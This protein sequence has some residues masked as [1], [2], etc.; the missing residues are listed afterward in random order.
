MKI[1]IEVKSLI[2]L[3]FLNL[4]V[5]VFPVWAQNNI[6]ILEA[7]LNEKLSDE[8]RIDTQNEL[9][10]HF[11][12]SN[13][14]RALKLSNQTLVNS[15]KLHYL[16]GIGGALKVQGALQ[17]LAGNIDTALIFYKSSIEAFEE[18]Q[19]FK[20]QAEVYLLWGNLL[21]SQDDIDAAVE[22]YYRGLKIAG[23]NETLLT[24]ASLLMSIGAI[25]V[26]QQN[27]SEAESLYKSAIEIQEQ[28]GLPSKYAISYYHLAT[29]YSKTG[30][31][32]SA[33]V[34][35]NKA[36]SIF[37][38]PIAKN[39]LASIY[40]SK[41]NV[42]FQMKDYSKA[43]YFYEKGFRLKKELGNEKGLANSYHQVG[44]L[45]LENGLLD[46]AEEYLNQSLELAKELSMIDLQAKTCK[47]MSELF[48]QLDKPEDAL[49]YYQQHIILRDSIRNQET[50]R[51]IAEIEE[52][53]NN[54]LLQEKNEKQA[55]EI[56]RNKLINSGITAVLGFALLTIF[57]MFRNYQQKKKHNLLVAT[58]KE[59]LHQKEVESLKQLSELRSLNAIQD[60]Q[61]IERKRIAEALH[62][63]LGSVLSA[64]Q[65]HIQTFQV[66]SDNDKN[67]EQ[68]QL[69]NKTLQLV[70]NAAKT[71]RYIAHEMMPPVLMRFG[72]KAA[73]DELTDKL[74]SPGVEVHTSVF[75]MEK[76]YEDKLE[77]ALYRII[78]ELLNNILKHAKATEINVQLTEHDDSL[79]IIVEDNGRGFNYL[80][81]SPNF[82][83]GLFNIQARVK[84]FGGDLSVDS[85]PGNGTTVSIDIPTKKTECKCQDKLNHI[86]S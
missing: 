56:N 48:E 67:E 47:K 52:K 70:K 37:L 2:I 11:R 55:I 21:N 20:G 29:L 79:N 6:A 12:R 4:S 27:Y 31:L 15:K 24:K 16:K 69:L 18:C 42:F 8:L 41:G 60:G 14:K 78:D 61:E 40:S 80:P 30:Q 71:N 45:F 73:L 83:M 77:L 84:H 36:E 81:K 34:Y 75:G 82:G 25:K 1:T 49:T 23:P 38:K 19:Y 26:K 74:K 72:L 5:F 53:Y 57:L 39:R 3:A 65:M 17:Y 44:N 50:D 35:F 13:A 66:S 85:S 54:D 76:R 59:E 22:I 7:K 10:W 62:N 51:Q 33:L 43:K 9:A 86:L 63:S 32:D 64:I 46:Q 28:I 58:Q 68:E